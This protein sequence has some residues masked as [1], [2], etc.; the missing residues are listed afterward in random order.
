MQRDL[1]VFFLFSD[2]IEQKNLSV[3]IPLLNELGG[4]PVL[5]SNPGGNWNSANFDLVSLLVRLRAYNNRPLVSQYVSSD[6]KN[7][8][9][10]IIY[11]SKIV[12]DC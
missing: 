9:Q 7:S 10:R 4:W 5:G 8:T 1:Y 6:Y 11:V 12:S 2:L 3:A